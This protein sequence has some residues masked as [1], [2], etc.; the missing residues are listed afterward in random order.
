[1]FGE[2]TKTL[3][4]NSLIANFVPAALLVGA[5]LALVASGILPGINRR[6]VEV[7][8]GS[9]SLLLLILLALIALL[10]QQMGRVVLRMYEGYY[11]TFFWRAGAGL[12]VLLG[13]VKGLRGELVSWPW[14]V[15]APAAL[16]IHWLLHRAGRWRHVRRFKEGLAACADGPGA[17]LRRFRF[18]REYPHE[19]ALVLPT[20]LGNVTRAFE[21][22]AAI[23][24]NLDPITIWPRLSA[25][26]PSAYRDAIDG[27]EGGFRFVLNMSLV[28]ALFGI[29]SLY[30]QATEPTLLLIGALCLA[31]SFVA[32]LVACSSAALWG[33]YVRGAF[34]LYRLDLLKQLGIYL[35]P[36]P[37]SLDEER[38]VWSRVQKL[39]FYVE[40]PDGSV[41][42]LP[43][44][45][46]S[47]AP[48]SDAE[49]KDE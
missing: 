17:E 3:G 27:T 11:G 43:R 38:R 2:I 10:L 28:L 40:S 41:K 25:V 46:G 15:G 23:L 1:M 47:A 44:S 19:E 42:F 14:L 8:G 36:G 30:L 32:Y 21:A 26:V 18:R 49:E 24:Y 35:R 6:F 45:G 5:N 29:E 13:A 37:M 22:H 4:R 48:R 12:A 31:A 16:L 33:E 20:K 9:E 39:T 7:T 34:D